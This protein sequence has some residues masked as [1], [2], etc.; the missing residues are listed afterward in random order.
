MSDYFERYKPLIHEW[1]AFQEAVQRPLPTTIWANPIKTTP[2]SLLKLLPNNL[3]AQPL[4]WLPGAFRL[5]PDFPSGL[6]WTYLAGLYHVQEEVSLLPIT[7][8][9]PQLGERTLDLCA[10]P[11]NKTAQISLAMRNSGSVI[12]NDRNIGR[13]RATRHTLDRLGIYNVTTTVY[14]GGNFPRQAG[15]FD[16]VL[17][18]AP[19][20]CEG[21]CRKDN[22]I[23]ANTGVN[24]QKLVG[25]QRALLRKA[26][27][28]CRPGGRIVYA[29]CTFAPEENELVVD[30]ILREFGEKV[31]MQP[32]AIPGFTA[33]PG[34]THWQGQTLDES[35]HH[36]LRVWPHQNDTGGFFVAVL[37]KQ[38]DTAAPE[39]VEPPTFTSEREPWLS[40]IGDHYG[41]DS[42]QFEPYHLIRWSRKRLYLV[43]RNHQ[44]VSRPQPDAVGMFFM[45]IDGKYPKWTTGAAQLFGRYATRQVVDLEPE[46]AQAYLARQDCGLLAQQTAVCNGTGYALVRYQGIPLGVGVYRARQGLLESLFPKGW[47]RAG[48]IM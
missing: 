23:F 44:S 28:L 7:L 29:T 35:L 45:H 40:M 48:A 24:S 16:R 15:P 27:Q 18:D 5:P 14:D 41:I 46:Q 33:S 2:D 36:A 13:M 30:A 31:Q 39:T 6:H 17:V 42:A 8:L 19:C 26:V 37:Q 38:P 21:T 34:V 20:T 10:A 47:A 22:G 25:T 9:D 4:P 43:N 11:G 12:A 1:K 32:A 3:E